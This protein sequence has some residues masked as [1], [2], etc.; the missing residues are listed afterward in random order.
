MKPRVGVGLE[1]E[2]QKKVL[3]VDAELLLLLIE[4]YE[5]LL[6]NSLSAGFIKEFR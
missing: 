2:L 3:E 4:V 1:K 5:E 6:V